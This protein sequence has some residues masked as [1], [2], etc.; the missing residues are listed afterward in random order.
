[1]YAFGGQHDIAR[2]SPFSSRRADISPH[3]PLLDK[4]PR[5]APIGL[6]SFARDAIRSEKIDRIRGREVGVAVDRTVAQDDTAKNRGDDP[7]VARKLNAKH[8]SSR[9]RRLRV[10]TARCDR[11]GVNWGTLRER[12]VAHEALVRLRYLVHAIVSTLCATP[13]S[14]CLVLTAAIP[15]EF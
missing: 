4:F 12:P 3:S 6:V 11:S 14:R 1:M 9:A 7:R 2:F 15:F 13:M 5:I 10:V 8:R